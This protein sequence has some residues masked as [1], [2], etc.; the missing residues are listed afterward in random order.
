MALWIID[1]DREENFK[2]KYLLADNEW[3]NRI[4]QKPDTVWNKNQAVGGNH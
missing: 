2:T 1:H 4:R 3:K